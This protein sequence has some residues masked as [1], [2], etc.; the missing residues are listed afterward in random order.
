MLYKTG[1]ADGSHTNKG[2]NMKEE[3]KVCNI[4]TDHILDGE[5]ES[6]R[7]CPIALAIEQEIGS[8]KEYKDY[9]PVILNAKDMHLE[10]IKFED[11]EILAIDVFEGD[12]EDVDN[13]I[14]DFD[15]TFSSDTE[16]LPLPMRFRYRII[17]SK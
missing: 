1:R 17:R 14:W 9:S 16:P 6:A 12:R 2:V 13:F 4:Q 11:K 15:K 7:C 8:L 10:K 5:P 3:W